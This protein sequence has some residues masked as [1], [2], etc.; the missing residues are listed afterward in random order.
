MP[1]LWISLSFIAGIVLAS[2]F[3]LPVWAWILIS[4]VFFL[5]FLFLRNHTLQ[6]ASFTLSPLTLILP[7]FLFLGSSYYQ[8]RQPNIN[9]FHIAFYNDRNY[10]LLI[11]GSLAE[12]PDYRDNYT[13]LKLKVEAVDTG[14]GDLPVSG[15]ILVRVPVNGG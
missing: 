1:L 10:D 2:V 5:L 14:S 13:N 3:S 12:P 7:V 9:A 6:V 15:F 4:V 11:T 8:F